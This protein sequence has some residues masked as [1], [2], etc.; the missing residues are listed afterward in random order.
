MPTPDLVALL[1]ARFV[2]RRENLE[3]LRAH[4]HQ[5]R[6]QRAA[7]VPKLDAAARELERERGWLA[8]FAAMD[9]PRARLARRVRRLERAC[10]TMRD[11]LAFLD[12][13]L[14]QGAYADA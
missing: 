13:A 8:L 11:E 4:R 9:W 5:L 10:W 7:L 1:A 3:A 6:K 12:Y 2:K 14:E